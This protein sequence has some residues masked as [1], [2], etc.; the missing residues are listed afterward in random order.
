[1]NSHKKNTEEPVAS[2][3][4]QDREAQ[5]APADDEG[6]NGEPTDLD[7]FA[8][9]AVA[10]EI[11]REFPLVV[12]RSGLVLY[13]VDPHE[14]QAQWQ[15]TDENLAYA[16]STFPVG[17]AGVRPVLRLRRV[18]DDGRVEEVAFA[19][20]QMQRSALRGKA[21]FAVDAP[22]ATF[23]AELGFASEDGGWLS[24]LRSNRVRVARPSGQPTPAPADVRGPSEVE[25]SLRDAAEIRSEAPEPSEEAALAAEGQPLA[26]AFPLAGRAEEGMALKHPLRRETIHPD[27]RA[28]EETAGPPAGE[29]RAAP[30]SGGPGSSSQTSLPPP[31]LPSTQP[32]AVSASWFTSFHSPSMAISSRALHGA[33]SQEKELE[34]HAELLIYG[35]ARPGSLIDLFGQGL[36]VGP[37]GHFFVRRP[38]T[39]PQVLAQ[40]LSADAPKSSGESDA[41]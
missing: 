31:L 24:L 10:E 3:P 18:G 2:V 14:L 1:M 39:D 23:E 36:R 12:E 37:D 11:N 29:S 27:A 8:L 17:A 7:S 30:G 41:E 40:A 5:P 9:R 15:V 16:R 26:P 6:A 28:H 13:D 19:P 38:L 25:A 34:V 20:Q 35:R 4:K 21:R 22:G 32:G 33:P